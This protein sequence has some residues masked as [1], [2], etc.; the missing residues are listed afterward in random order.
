MRYWIRQHGE[1]ISG[2][3]DLEAI[4]A[5]IRDGKVRPEMEFSPDGCEWI[6]GIELPE[7]FARKTQRARR[8]RHVP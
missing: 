4:R 7:L 6:W 3:H 5:W 1:H 2:P 8:R